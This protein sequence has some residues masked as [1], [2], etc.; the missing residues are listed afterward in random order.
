M[1]LSAI[2]IF[3]FFSDVHNDNFVFNESNSLIFD[4]IV[5]IENILK[6]ELPTDFSFEQI[7]AFSNSLLDHTIKNDN[8]L[9][10]DPNTKKSFSEVFY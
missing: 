7:Q 10:H 4:F 2:H 5:S 8:L 6:I 1:T 9:S 3:I